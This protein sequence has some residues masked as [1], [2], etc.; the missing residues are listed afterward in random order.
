MQFIKE[1]S[2]FISQRTHSKT[3]VELVSI[4]N[5]HTD[6]QQYIFILLMHSRLVLFVSFLQFYR[7][8][9]PISLTIRAVLLNW[10]TV[11]FFFSK[12][13]ILLHIL[14]EFF[15]NLRKITLQCCFGLCHTTVQIRHNYT[16]ITSL[17]SLPS[18][19]PTPSFT[20]SQSTGWD[21]CFIQQLLTSYLFHTWWCIYVEMNL[22]PVI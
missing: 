16:S 2:A 6:F 13:I 3:W 4:T 8:G 22:E 11:F 19:P 15:F 1:T 12:V 7:L 21:P 14:L 18:H 10:M 9:R 5:F 20:S 17:L